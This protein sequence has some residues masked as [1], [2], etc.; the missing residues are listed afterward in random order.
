MCYAI[1]GKVVD[2]DDRFVTVEYFGEKKRALNEIDDLCIGDYIYAQGGYVIQKIDRAEAEGILNVWKET[3]FDL[4]EVDLRLSRIKSDEDG[5]DPK[6]GKLLDKAVEG[7][8]LNKDEL[9]QLLKL[10]NEKEIELLLKVG[11]FLRQKHLG[12][13]CCVHGI[14]EFSNYCPRQCHYCGISALNKNIDR[15]RLSKEEIVEIACEAINKYGFKALVLQSGEDPAYSVDDLC[16]IIKEIKEKAPVLIFISVGEVGIEGLKK[17]HQAG[18][19]GI[20][21]RF[22]TSNPDLYHKIH[23]GQDLNYRIR[24]LEEAYK[25]GYLIITGGLIGLPDQAKED[26]L[27]DILLAKSLHSEMYSFGPFLPHPETPF[28][29]EPK[30][31]TVD[32]LKALA[33]CRIADANEGKI[34]VTT[35]FETLEPQARQKGLLAGANSVMLNVTPDRFKHLYSIYPNR[36]HADE[37][38]QEQIDITLKILRDIGRAPTDLG[39]STL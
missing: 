32:I 6:V 19:R 29:N 13:S 20:L 30:P 35:G 33:V 14:I 2:I 5:I 39:I 37:G 25:M 10:T 22:E 21:L 9:L 15:Y 26:I 12:N 11:N 1:P 18:A 3:F 38:L 34:L 28:S 24:H 7:R 36:A 23:P 16:E 17:L 27:N 8:E 4:Q 31:Q